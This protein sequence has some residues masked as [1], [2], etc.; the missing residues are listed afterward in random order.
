VVGFGE[1]ASGQRVAHC[2]MMTLQPEAKREKR[3]RH[4]RHFGEDNAPQR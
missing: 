4:L 2:P 1:G 3:C